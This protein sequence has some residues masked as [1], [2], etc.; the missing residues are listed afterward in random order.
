MEGRLTGAFEGMIFGLAFAA[1]AW[2]IA[3][4]VRKVSG[5]NIGSGAYY[6]IAIGAGFVFRHVLIIILKSG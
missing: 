3:L 2:V 1:V 6:G 5:K 4:V